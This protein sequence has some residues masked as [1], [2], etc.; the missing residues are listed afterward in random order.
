MLSEI[1]CNIYARILRARG[2]CVKVFDGYLLINNVEYI[3]VEPIETLVVTHPR[4]DL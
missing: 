2:F 4:L 1:Q 3:D